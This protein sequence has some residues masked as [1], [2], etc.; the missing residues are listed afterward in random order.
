MALIK[1][2]ECGHEVSD[3]A[4]ACPN[5]GCPLAAQTAT[6]TT[7][8]VEEGI[9]EEVSTLKPKRGKRFWIILAAAMVVL[10]GV[11]AIF[12]QKGGNLQ[13]LF[14]SNDE[15]KIT[16][17]F[18][19]SIR[20][21]ELLGDFHEGLAAAVRKVN[22]EP[23]VGYINTKGE[24]VI[25][26]KFK[27]YIEEGADDIYYS[28][29]DFHEG[30]AKVIDFEEE[31]GLYSS[32]IVER[33]GCLSIRYGFINTKGELVIPY[34]DDEAN[35][36]SEGFSAT[37]SKKGF[38]YI[39]KKG[40]LS[41]NC[42]E[43]CGDD[44][45]W[46]NS[47]SEGLALI[48]YG[49]KKSFINN[50]GEVV[51]DCSEYD[52]VEHFSEGLSYV[53]GDYKGFIDKSGKKI[54]DCSQ[55]NGEYDFVNSFSEGL[56][57]VYKDGKVGFINTKGQVVIPFQFEAKEVEGGY[58]SADFHEGLCK[59]YGEGHKPM[60]I[61]KNGKKVFDCNENLCYGDAF[62]NGVVKVTT[63]NDIYGYAD[64]KGNTTFTKADFA[65]MD[66]AKKEAI[67]AAEE[68]RAA[69]EAA[70]L[71]PQWAQG[72][73]YYSAYGS[74]SKVVINGNN[75]AVYNNN[76]LEYSGPYEVRDDEIH[77]TMTNGYGGYIP[78]DHYN[79]VLKADDTHSFYRSTNEAARNNVESAELNNMA[80]LKELQDKGRELVSE[81]AIMRS[82]GQI[83]PWR[84]VFIKTNVIRYKEEQISIAEKLGDSDLTYQYRQQLQQLKDALRAMEP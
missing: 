48:S 62:S 46:L 19:D 6:D 63:L 17:A 69:E 55:Y 59:V 52:K 18:S 3:R 42:S 72:T 4:K 61:D 56:A 70:K 65:K 32:E 74:M 73:W 25:P 15:V 2:S 51:L 23:L 45:P 78:M 7:D 82:S 71:A 80:R 81:L 39:D 66:K 41:I 75:I 29:G 30:L 5:C 38:G 28:F 14:Q 67:E 68:A 8:N 35:D 44:Y 11:G 31:S 9:R 26:C 21:Y 40:N 77:Y 64:K 20:K 53:I 84:L 54:I 83:D 47:F 57:A 16:K 49:G 12:L 22:G 79:E 24:E 13:S 60:F 36:F 43:L 37:N 1:C 27:Y 58:A 34:T 10:L 33:K 50:K 76:E